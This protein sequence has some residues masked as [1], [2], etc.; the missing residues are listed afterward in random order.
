VTGAD[1]PAPGLAGYH[2]AALVCE[3]VSSESEDRDRDTKLLDYR[4]LPSLREYVLLDSRRRRAHRY[5]L[6]GEAWH[7]TIVL[8][9]GRLALDSI[10]LSLPL[11]DLYAGT[12]APAEP[13]A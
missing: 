11:D 7:H 13:G 3:V 12:G 10:S 4:L 6:V 1:L 9:T 2:D 8:S 5:L